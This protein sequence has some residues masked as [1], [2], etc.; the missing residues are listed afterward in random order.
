MDIPLTPVLEQLINEK[1][2]SGRYYSASEVIGEA[3]R[4]L[5]ERDRTQEERLAEL[6]GKIRVGIEASERGEVIDGE[7]FFAELEEN[8]Q[9]IEAE[10]EQTKAS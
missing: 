4:L 5:D 1:V 9:R 10:M 7:E 8:I 6:K 3:L 2:N